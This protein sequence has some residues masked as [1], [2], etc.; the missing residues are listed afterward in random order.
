MIVGLV[1]NIRPIKRIE[2]LVDAVALL[3]CQGLDVHAAIVGSGDPEPLRDRARAT[4]VGERVHFL[5]GRS[6]VAACLQHFHVGAL[7]SES[8]GFSNTLLEYMRA[9]LPVVCTDAGGNLEAVRHGETG[10]LYPVGDVE[11]LSQGLEAILLHREKR[12]RMGALAREE[13][14]ER[15]STEVMVSAHMDLYGRILNGK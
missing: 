7:C 3:S 5:G 11:A 14:V 8:E 10:F 4:G 15:Y 2:D 6:D 9:G 1:A 12:L 13:A